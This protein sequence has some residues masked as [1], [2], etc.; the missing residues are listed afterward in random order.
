MSEWNEE[1]RVGK[2]TEVNGLRRGME[3]NGWDGKGREG[4]E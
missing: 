1:G 2:G 3:W 4:N